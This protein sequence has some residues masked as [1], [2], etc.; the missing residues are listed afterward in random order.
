MPKLL[1]HLV[2]IKSF[3]DDDDSGE[4]ED[5]MSRNAIKKNSQQIVDMKTKKHKI[6]PRKT[7]GK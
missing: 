6:R 4:D 5:F 7:K 2:F 3:S 1:T